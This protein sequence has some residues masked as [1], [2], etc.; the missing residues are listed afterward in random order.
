[1]DEL[2]QGGQ[3]DGRFELQGTLGRGGMGVVYRAIDRERGV[4][5]ALKTLR[6]VS[7]ARVLRFKSE[8][9]AL[10]DLRHPNLVE[11][12][13]LFESGGTWFFTMELVRGRP[14]L[15]WV[16]ATSVDVDTAPTS[17]NGP[18]TAQDS[19]PSL[20]VTT[21]EAPPSV[22]ARNIARGSRRRGERQNRPAC[23]LAR[24]VQALG[25][26][27]RGLAALHG[28]A[29]VHRDIKPSNILV[30]EGGRLV[31]L[32]FG[33]V[34]E[35]HDRQQ[36]GLLFGTARYMAPE[37]ARG[38]AIGPAADWYAVGVL[39]FEALTGELPF[40]EGSSDELLVL[41]Q[42]VDAPAPSEL[43]DG[44]PPELDALVHGLLARDPAGR[45]TAASIL[46]ALGV[47]MDDE[48][49]PAPAGAGEL[50]VGRAAE[51]AQLDAA[52]AASR[53]ATAHVVIEGE[54]GVGK[55]ALV[56]RFVELARAREPRLLVLRGRCHE[57]ERV[58][59]NVLDGVLDDLARHLATRRDATIERVAP[60][61]VTALLAVFPA[62]RAVKRLVAAALVES[63]PDDDDTDVRGR[64]FGALRE[65][66]ARLGR[67]RPLAVVL[68]D[69]QWADADSIALLAELLRGAPPLCVIETRRPVPGLPVASHVQHVEL[70]GLD[71]RDA[72]ELV[73]RIGGADAAHVVAESRGHPLFL[74]ELARHGAAGAASLE[75]VI[76]TRAS[77]LGDAARRLL[78][79]IAVAG[80][81]VPREVAC[82]AAGLTVAE[83]DPL[84]AALAAERLVRVHGPRP[85]DAVEAFHDRV[86]GAVCGNVGS[87]IQRALHARI[88]RSLEVTG[89]S[90]AA[91][92]A[93]F[94][95]AGDHDRVSRYLIAAADD[96]RAAFAF[97][98]V[99][100][101]LRRALA[102][103]TLAKARRCELLV[104]LADA[105]ANDGRTADAARCYLEAAE[106]V[107]PES[108]QHLDLLRRAAERF[109][110]SGEVAD[111]LATARAVLARVDMRLPATRARVLAG[112]LWNQ[113]RMRGNAFHW[114]PRK[115]TDPRSLDA[116]VC[117]SIGAG[118]GMIDSL[119][120]AYFSGRAARLALARGTPL[121][122]ARG[123]AAASI[124]AGLLGRRD[125]AHRLLDAA[126]RA[127]GE[128]GTPLAQWYVGLAR[129]GREFLVENQFRRANE[130]ARSLE[131]EWYA[132]G[133]GPGWETDVAMHFSLASQQMLGE[134]RDMARRVARLV[135][136]AHRKGDLF[137]EVT[138]RVRFAV[139]HLLD[140]HADT[141][142]SDVHGALAAWLPGGDS[143]GNQRAWGLWSRTRIELYANR[144]ATLDDELG[145][146]WQ[147][148]G[149][150]LVGRLPLMQG[151]WLHA[152]ATFLLARAIAAGK[153]GR[154]SEHATLCRAADR[155]AAR[156]A[157]L[158]F[159]AAP[160][161][162][163]LVRAGT[164]WVRRDGDVVAVTRRALDEAHRTGV[165]AFAHPTERRLGEA[166]GGDEGAALIARADAA[167][168]A[169][170]WRDPERAAE[171]A[172]P[173]GR[174]AE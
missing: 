167:M 54:S 62:L 140:D 29:K 147:R 22:V 155:V 3:I 55:S 49:L 98:Q 36:E 164:A 82:E 45:P 53:H 120:G 144:F 146:E 121:Q 141:G 91:L 50:F 77:Q 25:G 21:A 168:R 64:A 96:A 47:D 52:L 127:A 92:L 172:M 158:E 28:A 19:S 90:A 42:H 117:W 16:A 163:W 2:A 156:L 1:V 133:Q 132:A 32:D 159:P 68:D 143:F 129:T 138:L 149:R 104:A 48:A 102:D 111:G 44:V 154:M 95:A 130:S 134:Y 85:H 107:R 14:F 157:R 38:D 20:V 67:R 30:E 26:L 108:E 114:T 9:R 171:L 34:A 87:E 40:G 161:A 35:L 173:T 73:R 145:A 5:V 103:T 75:Q 6:G 152:Y 43:V 150:S 12:G 93:H 113:L 136:R 153:A 139:R 8:F 142:R 37:Q 65:L 13:E 17:A 27:V 83:G 151:E 61:G 81:P 124:G 7:P 51:L 10:R 57:R 69:M 72:E 80:S 105:L 100:T 33:V 84:L 76:W 39:M 89:A 70:G 123:M 94:E 131:A 23:D 101:L 174:F 41:K 11:L 128:D 78:A 18:L 46:D 165:L 115:T 97:G 31:L 99:A 109:L 59:F 56:A 86:R 66:F 88:A 160:C 162:E 126:T 137:Q 169:A 110:M 15:E 112:I 148:M 116:D 4:E 119:L 170:G 74:R 58:P 71:A 60:D 125:R 118:L 24:L 106:L 135:E 166:L 122:I 79:V 63:G